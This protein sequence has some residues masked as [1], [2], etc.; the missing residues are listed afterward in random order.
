MFERLG[1]APWA[2][3]TRSGL[4]RIGGRAPGTGGLTPSEQRVAALVAEGHSNKEVAAT[5][6][7][8]VKTVEANLSH[9]YAKLGLRSR[10]ELAHRFADR[11]GEP[12]AEPSKP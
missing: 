3:K 2:E 6:F 4:A 10:T 1:A 11:R 5:L 7:V 8:T 9:V 12:E